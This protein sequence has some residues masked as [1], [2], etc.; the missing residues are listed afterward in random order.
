[1]VDGDLVFGGLK[2]KKKKKNWNVHFWFFLEK[3]G[4]FTKPIKSITSVTTEYWN[5]FL[6][7]KANTSL[8][9]RLRRDPSR[10]NSTNRQNPS[11]QQNPHNFWT[12]EAMFMFFEI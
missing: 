6:S 4:A 5:K 7:D 9:C 8:L 11:A 3:I 10:S 1:M 12:N 2:R